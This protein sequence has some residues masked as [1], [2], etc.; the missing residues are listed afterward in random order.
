METGTQIRQAAAEG[1]RTVLVAIL[2]S[3][4]LAAVK[5]VAG[6]TGN[7]Y[8]L[9]ADGLE[10]VLDIFC[11]LVV[12]SAIRISIA[13]QTPRFPY[14]LGKAEPLS[15]LAVATV[16]GLA[17]VGIAVEAVR[18][19]R[20][21]HA[22]PAVFTL[23]VL[24]AVI[25]VKEV[26]FRALS[27]RGDAIG[28][29]AIRTDAWHHRSDALT[30][31]AVFVGISIA[32]AGGEGWEAADDW[33]ALFACGVIEVNAARLLRAALHDVLDVAAPQDVERRIRTIAQSVPGVE[34]IDV[35]R[36]RR[37]GLAYLVDIHAEVDGALSV[38]RGH[39]IAHLVK[40]AL[41]RSEVPIMDVLVHIEPAPT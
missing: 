27:T 24:A 33:A 5:I 41:I 12:L 28:S 10:S 39:Q 17:G 15:A 18:E 32:L 34:S 4:A 38:R 25:A 6:L 9:V 3:A 19:I 2:A 14:G 21:P 23:F 11:S 20:T 8:A 16:L 31:L 1:T 37:S 29:Q 36:V 40:D 22:A 26:T 35:C 30:S 7:S 13:P